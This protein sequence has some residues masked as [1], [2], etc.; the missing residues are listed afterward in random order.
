[1]PP[2]W[3]QRSYTTLQLREHILLAYIAERLVKAAFILI[4]ILVLNFMLI[5]AAPGDPAAVMAGE[6]GAADEKFLQDLRIRFGLDQPFTVQLW[7]YMKGAIQLDL[8]YSY[9]QQM[10]INLKVSML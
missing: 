4:A 9:R 10:P 6:A 5:H 2:L 8:G 3:A 1:M 7:T